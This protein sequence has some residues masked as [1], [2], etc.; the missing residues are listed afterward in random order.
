MSTQ[1]ERAGSAVQKAHVFAP[2]GVQIV[3]HPAGH[4]QAHPNQTAHFKVSVDTGLGHTGTTIANSLL[5][6]CEQDFL[7][8][9]GYLLRRY[10]ARVYAFHLIVTS[11][12]QGASHATCAATALSI[13]RRYART[14]APYTFRIAATASCVS[15]SVYF[16]LI[17]TPANRPRISMVRG[18]HSRP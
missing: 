16:G 11:G 14:T 5:Q 12:N 13:R 3:A 18:Q 15:R 17:I 9:Q 10:N 7:T 4:Q 8:L 2:R 6:T 1:P